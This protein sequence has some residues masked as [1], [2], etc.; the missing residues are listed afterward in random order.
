MLGVPG[1]TVDADA[2]AAFRVRFTDGA[3]DAS[4][5]AD[6]LTALD[7]HLARAFEDSA[8]RQTLR[9][10][11]LLELAKLAQA[12]ATGRDFSLYLREMLVP[13]DAESARLDAERDAEP[14]CV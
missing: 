9:D 14:D 5:T 8:A 6:A 4:A 11:A 12:S 7:E 13:D 10:A 1:L 2:I 3:L